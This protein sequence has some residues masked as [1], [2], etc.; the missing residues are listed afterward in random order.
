MPR[1]RNSRLIRMTAKAERTDSTEAA[2]GDAS[3]AL[4]AMCALIRRRLIERGIDPERVAALRLAPPQEPLRAAD[5]GEEFVLSDRDGLAAVFAEKIGQ[6]AERYQDGCEPDFANASLAEL[7]AWC[8]ARGGA[9]A[10]DEV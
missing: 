9:P 1:G 4:A 3:G 7:L 10:K 8:L 5:V 6:V 2:D